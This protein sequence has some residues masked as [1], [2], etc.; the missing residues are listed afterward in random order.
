MSLT[1]SPSPTTTRVRILHR[2][3]RR[4]LGNAYT[5]AIR[6]VP[7][8]DAEVICQMDA[9][10]SHDPKYL[11]DLLAAL[12]DADVSIGSRYTRGISVVNWPLY[13][14]ALSTL[15]NRCV[16]VTTGLPVRDCTS[17]FRA[18]RRAAI[19]QILLDRVDSH[20]SS[21]MVETL[22]EAHRRGC[23]YVE[24]PIVFVDRSHGGSKLSLGVFLESMATPLKLRLRRLVGLESRR[25]RKQRHGSPAPTAGTKPDSG[26]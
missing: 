5:D 8:G 10:W 13:R 4:G 14:L 2:T 19:A 12:S 9:D 25:R 17:G 1:R 6:D 11:P 16:Q 21:F 22:Y 24:V 26:R 20:G 3:T 7:A 18:W 23:R 15:A